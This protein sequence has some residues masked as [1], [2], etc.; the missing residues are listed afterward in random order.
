MQPVGHLAGNEV[1][2]IVQAGFHTLPVDLIPTGQGVD[3]EKNDQREQQGLQE[4][5]EPRPQAEGAAQ[6]G[7]IFYGYVFF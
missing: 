6:R 7:L 3:N 1:L 5:L 2:P 4:I